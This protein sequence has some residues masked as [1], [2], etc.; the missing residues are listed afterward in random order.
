MDL[1]KI[2][3]EKSFSLLSC[4]VVLTLIQRRQHS[5]LTLTETNFLPVFHRPSSHHYRVPVLNEL[6]LLPTRQLNVVPSSPSY[7][8]QTAELFLLLPADRSRAKHVTCS[9]VAACDCVMG[10]LLGDG[11]VH[12]L[13]VC[14]ANCVRFLELCCFDCYV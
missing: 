12:V 8:Q 1:Y 5:P 14:C 7:L 10:K 6:P 11:P 13:E 2:H 3:T 4:S 9:H